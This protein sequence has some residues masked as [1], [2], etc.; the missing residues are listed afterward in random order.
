MCA[1][2]THNA[3]IVLVGVLGIALAC[4]GGDGGGGEAT[5]PS[6]TAVPE[7]TP[8]RPADADTTARTLAFEGLDRSY[9]LTIP[10]GYDGRE[11][12]PL[13][14]NLHGFTADGA[15][16]NA[17][18]GMP[19]VAG[20]RGYVVVTPDGGPLE[21]PAV[22]AGSGGA[23]YEGQRFWNMFGPGEVDFGP[24]RGQ[25]IGIDSSEVG[26]DDVGFVGA[27]LDTL[28]TELCV[29]SDRLYAAGMSNGAG[30]SA[31]LGCTLGDRLAAIAPVSGVNLTGKCPES[32]PVA[33]LAIHGDADD[34]VLYGGNGLLGL[35]FGNPSVP[36]RMAQWAERDRCDPGPE[37]RRPETGLTIERWAGCARGV[38][39]ELWT[40]AGWGHAW[41]RAESPAEPGV[42]DATTVVLDFFDAHPRP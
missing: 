1:I 40:I 16:Q 5:E 17:I 31:M 18:T 15:S 35:S 27:L 29:D 25:N 12:A 7:C 33:V 22:L 11:G 32:G 28:E 6:G 42:I 36:E 26:A 23:Q 20:A 21:I 39:V 2:V 30:M 9:L 4:S 14:V 10:E 41:P 8:A 24:P 37:V 3:R 34:V 19:E 38:D 13:V